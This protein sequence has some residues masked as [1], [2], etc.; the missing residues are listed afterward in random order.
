MG[1]LKNINLKEKGVAI[2]GI[3]FRIP[4]GNNENSISSPDDLFNNLKNGFDGVSSTSERWSDNF[5][6]L[7]EISSPNAGLLPF[8]EWKSFDPL[9]FG[10]NPSEAP[11]ID[12]QQRLL[13]KCTWE[14]LEDASIDPISIRGTN[15]SVFI[16]SSTIDY[17]HTNKHQDSVLKNAIAQS[18]SAI[19]NRISYCFD[20]NGPSLSI[21]T[22]C[23]SSL[24]AVSQG[25]HSI[26]NGTSN[27]S[28]VGGVNLILDV[29]IIKAYSILSML[30]K[31][32]GKCKTFDESGDGFTRGE[33]VGVVVLKNLQDAVKDGNRIYCVINGSSSNVDG[34]GN[35]DKVNFYSPSKQSQFNNINSAFKSTNDKLSINDIQY[36]EAHGT[37]TK[38]GDPIETEAISMAFKNR[39]KSTPILIG[40]IKSNIGHCEAG[41]GVASLIK[42]CLM[43]KYQCFL[44]NIHFKNPNPLIKFNE[45]N[46]K[47]VTSPI[48]FNKRNNEK[49]VSMM[50][51]NFGV[52]GSN[53]CLLI[54][55]FKN[56]NNF[57]ENINLESQ[58]VNDRV[59]IPFSANSSNS[60]NQY[61]SK[62]K[63]IINNQFNFIDFTANQIYSKSNFLY[64][65]SVVIASNS[66]ELFENISNKKQIQTKNSI[67]SNMSFK[68][69]NPITIFV[70]SG[71]GSQY[72]KMALELYN[73]EVIFKKS[74]DL[75]D[76]KLSK[77]YGFSVWEKVKTIKDDDLTSIHDPI[78]AQPALCMI[79]VSLFEL[80]YHWGV[81]PSFILGHS[82]GEISASYCSGMIDLDTFC[83]TVYQRSIAQSKTNGC[84]R[85]L[86]INISDEE[87][88]SMYSQKYPQIEIACY[89]SPQSIVVAGNESI[90]NE[91]SKEL[92][93]KEI[94]T[95]M[96]GSLSSFHTSSQQCTKDSILQ[97][98]IESNQPKVPI[99]STVTTNL[100]NESNRFNSQYV[101]DNIIKPVKFTQTI[102]NIYKHIESNQLNNEI[103]FIEIAPHPTLLF[104]IKQMVPSSLNE[105]VSVY[106]ALHKKKND[107]EEFQQTI[108]NLYCQNGYNINFKCQFNNKKSNQSIN[109]PLY[110]WDEELY[111]TQAQ[112]LEQHRKEGPPIDHL[113]TS[114]SYNSPFNNSYRTSI[115]IKNKPFLYLKGHMVKGKYYF[116]GCGYIDNIIQLYKNQDIFISFIE[117]KTPLILIEGIN[118]Y[119]Q[120]NIQQTGKSEY[121]AQF[122]F[123][124]QKSNEWIQSSNANFQLLDHGN[125]IP[126]KYNI[127]EIIENKCNLSKLTKNELYTHIKSKTGLN[128]TGVFQGVTECYIGGD[129]TLSVVSLESQTN[130][131]LN[132]PILD[133]CLHGMIGLSND[134]C[135][136]VFDKAIGFKYYSSNI[137]ANLKDYKDSVYVYSHLKSKSV[138]SFFGSIIVMLS[139]GS[140]L[141]EIEEVVCKSL[142]PIKDSLK[143][144]YPNDE[145]YKVHLQSKDSPIP[146]PS[147]FK[148]IIYEN[149]FFHSALNIPEDL[150]KYISTLFYKDIIKRCP[151]ININK[152]NSHSVN[153][154]ISSFS[155]ISKHERLFRFVFETI[156]ENGILNSLEEND[157]AYFEFNEVIIK[158]SR[159]ISKLLFPLESDNDNEDLPQSLFQNGLMD[160]IY[161]CRY[162]R[163]KNQMISHVIKHSIKEII[164]NNIIIR[165]LEFGGGTAS[166]SVEVIE[167]IIA[168]LQENPNYQV[169]IEYTWSDI[170]PA[171]IADA[172]NK[173]N[174]IINDAAITNG[175]N[176]IYRPLKIDESLIETQSINPSYYDFVIM[177][178]VLHVVKNIKQAVEQMYQLL[179][180][181][182]QLLFLEPPYKSVLNDSIVGSFEQW[183]SFTDTDIRK[184]RCSMSQQSWCQLLK[185]CNFKDIAMSK[186]CIFVGIVIHAQK[187][188]ISLLNSQPKRDNIIIYGGGNPIFVENIK[189]YSNSKSLIQ[190]ETIQEFNQLL[191]QSTITNDSIIYFIKTLE[192]LSLDNFKQIT[193]EYIEINR[194]L[195]QIN[196]L[197]KHVLIVSDSRKTNYLASSVVGAARYFDEFQQL[198]L[199]TLDFDYDSTQNYINSNN[200]DMVQFINILT[201]SKTNV[202]KEM[203]IINNKVYYEIVQKEKNLKLKYNSESFEN[204]NNLMCSLSPNLEYQLQSKQIKLRDNQVEVKT[205]ATGINYKD[206]LNFSGSNS[207]GDDNTG[208]PQ[209]GYEFSGIITRVGNNVKDYKVGDNVFGL[210]NSCTSSHIVTNYKKIQ[211]KPSNLSHNEASSIPID[212]LTS[213][214]SLFNIGSLNIEDNESILI[215]LGSDGFGLSTFEIL[216]WKGFNSNLFVTVN[217]YETK[218]YLQDNYGDFITGIY[219]NTDKSYVTEINKKLIKLG[220]KKK[221]VDLILNTLPSD[222]MDSNFKLLAKYGR[223]IDLTSNH[224]NQSEFLKNINFKYNHGYHNFELSL[225]QKNKIHK[226]LYE[227]SNAFENGELKTIP[228]KEFTN[229][230]IKDAIKYITNNKIEKI[231]V[232]HD[233]E[234]YSDII[235]RSLDE[236]E[237]SILKSNYQINSNN[238]G[239]NILV[240]GQS[241]IILEILKWIIKY[242][243]INTIENV[244]ILSRSSLKWELELLINETKLSNNNIKFHFKSV[245]IG[246]SEQVDNAINEILNENQQITNIDSIYHF[247]FQQITCKVQEINMKHLDIS[248]GAKSMGAI[249]LHN[250]SIKRNWKLINFVMASSAISLIGSTDLCT[251]VCANALLDSF[252]K[253]RESLGLPSTCICLGAIESTGFVSKNESVSVFLDGGGFHPTPI[254]QVLGLLDLQ[255]QNAGKFTNS[256]LSNFKPS[257]FKNNQQTSLFLKFDYLMN[258][259]NNSE[260]TKIE[261]TGNKNIDELFI[262]KVSELFS[263]DE[264]KINKNLRLIDYGADSLIIVQLKNWIDKEI[265][266]NLITIQQLQNNTI[267]TSM[268]MILNS[269]MKNNQ[270]IDDNN[271]DL[272]SNRIDYWKNEM[273]FEESIKP[274]SNEI[275]SR[276]NSEKIILLTGTTGFLGGFLLFNMV[277][278][279][280]CKLIYCLIRNKSKSNNPL[281]E[282]INNL[283]YHQLYEKLNQSQIS[284]II[285]IIGDLSMNKLGLSN[286]D[287]ETISKNV[288]LIINP[289]ADIN[290]K[291]S[292][293]DCKLVN[294]NGVKEIIKLSL[295]SLKQRIPIVNFSSFSVFFNQSLDKNFDESVL[296]SIDN[297]DNLPTE[298]MKSK[299]VG[300]YILLEASKKYNIPSILIRPPSIFLNPETGIGHI[301][302]F[303]L[304]S[305]QSCYELGYY[306]N[307]FEN[308][309]I[310]INTI[311][312]LSNNITNIIMND[313]CWTD[314]KMNIYNVHGKQIQS[315][316]IIKPLEKH[317]NCKHINT[318]DWIDMVNNS[319]KKSCIKLKSF[320]SLDIILKSENNRY[321][322]NENQSIS[323]STKSLLESMGS[324]NT[325]LEITDKMIISHINQI[326]NLNETI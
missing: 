148:S 222:F 151:E 162:L 182:G 276:N 90:L 14:A 171:F 170:S 66:N 207:N 299:V 47:V 5:H 100:F 232:S 73:N 282:I 144:E 140:V 224:L 88:K 196:S 185:T 23:S 305:I 228:I 10:I 268:K 36:I 105:S 71:Q 206:Y 317:F 35:M 255:I 221:G 85:M 25:Y 203:I 215:H 176:V 126:P 216:K 1:N 45:W 281:D 259:K 9:F 274:I 59:L 138:D 122:H 195:L 204:Q 190:I 273:K 149:D 49:P 11:L 69:K 241:G 298:Y 62:F 272:P 209:F 237:F 202:H 264:S 324:Y 48:P 110:Q 291:S 164:N 41:S 208:L 63:N 51:N 320:H 192:T 168:L 220:S 177:S 251:Y 24:N 78:F 146:T 118:Q 244:I 181:N 304:L 87:F 284:K 161:K 94:F 79:S 124:D 254:N 76:S 39:D 8:K 315:S 197:C 95:T 61:Q 145:L 318:N 150:F 2:V 265:G 114:N 154:I 53:C 311:T 113:G 125:D 34:N 52:T 60:L 135:Q 115:D 142:I 309:F 89:N 7:G 54:S 245:D 263:M 290:Q 287:Y 133:T 3:G 19:S 159:I 199:N 130:S 211:I 174:K 160:K 248:H 218:R 319:N 169:E 109:L 64:Q 157:D 153:E 295:S 231:T 310:L 65:R 180:P 68:G 212:Y 278:L 283:K 233:H 288:N 252:S 307:Q 210:S 275:Q 223:I 312:W 143:I 300:E 16:G 152:I 227:I 280:S 246:D 42:C 107:V 247:A 137:P 67:I 313:N 242:S 55:E 120:T 194:K 253:Y 213:F 18:T 101:Y 261:N 40:S 229:L 99:F 96:L 117:F 147:S 22:A 257:K 243:N 198:K 289:G 81:N 200:K 33:C 56:N 306:P 271:K 4:S 249:N 277:R 239:K 172:K 178:N 323:L 28:I 179:T 12:P 158:S 322:P 225:I 165:I 15:T 91:I 84:G 236:K 58:S 186:E 26:L 256:M 156:K 108:S 240:T 167:E 187:P 98:N 32:H 294:V 86:S 44:P 316:L 238:L 325:D 136:I 235:Y 27:M 132:I 326:F 50:I 21:D 119:L 296:P 267:S 93:E 75:I 293:Q 46:L 279:D 217:S 31:T 127:K 266:I 302:D 260:E 77:Y 17:L 43:F 6:K 20:F 141:Y 173:I 201:D 166:L 321:K 37:G 250:Q 226:C 301:S 183:W 123:K 129:C 219:S 102:S 189:L 134:Q 83:Y 131:F 112:T 57:K 121:R 97:L 205:I 314:S 303:S 234:I 191:S 82:L 80:Y 258:L 92:K 103:V 188:P 30:S 297:I 29:D 308:D 13:L 111:F 184:D 230:N 286:D 262:E 116:P 269:L 193:L 155:K 74:I 292:Y 128:Y 104:Y 163:K 70:F 214:M 72:P 175:F 106:S 270:N 285:P 139:D 38:T